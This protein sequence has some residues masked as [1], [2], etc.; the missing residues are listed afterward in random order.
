M[1]G[2]AE[3]CPP[4]ALPPDPDPDVYVGSGAVMGATVGAVLG[5]LAWTIW[6][7]TKRV[8]PA[9]QVVGP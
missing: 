3:I 2:A 9:D 8:R 1:L 4:D 7:V 6:S 5:A